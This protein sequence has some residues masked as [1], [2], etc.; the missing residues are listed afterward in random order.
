MS[1]RIFLILQTPHICYFVTDVSNDESA[2]EVLLLFHN[3][4]SVVSQQM[5]TKSQFHTFMHIIILATMILAIMI[6]LLCFIIS[7]I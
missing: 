3:C 6:L 7:P 5:Y 2:K 4:F 1:R